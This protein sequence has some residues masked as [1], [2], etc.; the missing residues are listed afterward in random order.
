MRMNTIVNSNSKKHEMILNSGWIISIVIL[1]ILVL[2]GQ[3]SEALIAHDDWPFMLDSWDHYREKTLTEGRWLNYVWSRVSHYIIT[4]HFALVG[5]W[6]LF[7]YIANQFAQSIKVENP[8]GV[9]F[10]LAFI[11][12]STPIISFSAYPATFLLGLA[13]SALTIH[14]LM[15]PLTFFNRIFVVLIGVIVAFQSYPAF[16]FIIFA[17]AVCPLEDKGDIRSIMFMMSALIV[18]LIISIM[19]SF[20]LNR[21]THGIFGVMLPEWRNPNYARDFASAKAN[22]DAAMSHY[23]WVFGTQPIFS[24]LVAMGFVLMF[25]RRRQMAINYILCLSAPL[26]FDFFVSTYNGIQS[27]M[28]AF[29]WLPFFGAITAIMLIKSIPQRYVTTLSIVVALAGIGGIDRNTRSHSQQR[30]LVDEIEKLYLTTGAETVVIMDEYNPL[31]AA[32]AN[33]LR[34]R[35]IPVQWCKFNHVNCED[36][37]FE[38]EGFYITENRKK[39][40]VNLKLRSTIEEW[41]W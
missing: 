14:L 30:D 3:F 16:A 35:N 33:T 23:W 37:S 32:I 8:E 27:P 24:L 39:L 25:V 38:Q 28:R 1:V 15:R 20:T 6:I 19:L 22:I 2:L 17:F 11:L 34:Y 31:R 7:A 29:V 12:L 21:F 5:C 4:P 26:G 13:T 18:G 36:A 40:F 9:G 41:A 10:V